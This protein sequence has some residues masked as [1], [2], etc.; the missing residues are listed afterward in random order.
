MS[1]QCQYPDGPPVAVGIARYW[2]HGAFADR[3]A[4]RE[5][6]LPM[7]TGSVIGAIIGGLLLGAIP[8]EV[9]K[10]GLGVILIASAVRVFRHAS[11]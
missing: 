5:T 9:L 7:A 6:V 3:R 2:R 11:T 1:L 4:L 8:G 10:L